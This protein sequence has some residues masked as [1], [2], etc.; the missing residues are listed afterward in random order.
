MELY[1][2]RH[3]IAVER[4]TPDYDDDSQR[5][6]TPQGRKKMRRIAQGMKALGL[7]FDAIFSSPYRRAK[8]TGEIAAEVL[9]AQRKLKFSDQLTPDGDPKV[10][11][12]SLARAGERVLLVGHEPYLSSLAGQLIG[13]TPAM[14]LKLKK[15]GLCKLTADH[16][17][18][19]PCADLE[20]LLTPRHLVRLA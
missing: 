1:I 13:G 17:K 18:F 8:E 14:S 9:G 5:P 3:A 2:L 11:I 16:L 19:G 15:G 20:W 4:G 12:A 7:K 6:L 10:L